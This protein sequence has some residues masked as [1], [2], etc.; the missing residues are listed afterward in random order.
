MDNRKRTVR[1]FFKHN[2]F[3]VALVVCVMGAAAISLGAVQKLAGNMIAPPVEEQSGVLDTRPETVLPS[4]TPVEV[5]IAPEAPAD[6]PAEESV[7]TVNADPLIPLYAMPVDG[8]VTNPFSGDNLVKNA[9]LNDW[10]THNGMDIEAAAGTPVAAIYAGEVIRSE[11][12]PL[13]GHV[14]EMRLDTGYTVVY[15]NLQAPSTLQ[16][17]AR[18]SQ[19]D[20]LGH[21]GSSAL[22]ESAEAPHLHLEVRSGEKYIDPAGLY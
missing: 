19:G 17:G 3:Y 13:L 21:V 11:E 5:E 2:G 6:A 22:L 15:A 4:D 1:D 14:V 18:V 16:A 20:V 9:T 10:R 8:K 7:E 12:D